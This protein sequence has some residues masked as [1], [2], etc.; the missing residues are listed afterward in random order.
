MI[1]S[2]DLGCIA[3]YIWRLVTV[4]A[5]IT[6]TT[7]AIMNKQWDTVDWKRLADGDLR[8]FQTLLS[9]LVG[10]WE[11]IRD[12][13]KKI[14]AGYTDLKW[15]TQS[16]SS[17]IKSMLERFY[18]LESRD[19]RGRNLG[20]VFLLITTL[21]S[22]DEYTQ[23][24]LF[25]PSAFSKICLCLCFTEIGLQIFNCVANLA[26]EPLKTYSNSIKTMQNF[27]HEPTRISL[28][29]ASLLDLGS[30]PLILQEIPAMI[31]ELEDE[32]DKIYLGF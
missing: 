7:K 15:E 23:A 21:I 3:R 2:D 22:G 24:S 27:D 8:L 25:L 28:S 1:R 6:T 29:K 16:G 31:K 11:H 17:G 14:V 18:E 5:S 9:E 12:D 20:G 13:A 26:D 32:E 10:E 4:R 19:E 30:L